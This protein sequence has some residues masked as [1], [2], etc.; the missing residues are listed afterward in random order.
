MNKNEF[1]FNER[2]TGIPVPDTNIQTNIQLTINQ[3]FGLIV[4]LLFIRLHDSEIPFDYTNLQDS[5]ISTLEQI[6]R[7]IKQ[8]KGIEISEE[9]Q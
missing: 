5:T 9:E 8:G 2:N 3:D 4:D 1:N 6:I 7:K